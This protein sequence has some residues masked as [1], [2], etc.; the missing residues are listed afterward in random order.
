[1]PL[2]RQV[3]PSD[4]SSGDNDLSPK[5]ASG[6]I[7]V[8]PLEQGFQ[9]QREHEHICSYGD[10]AGKRYPGGSCAQGRRGN[11]PPG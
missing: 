2:K 6:F 7:V 8:L 3:V 10:M 5:W 11:D 1:M 9:K 4:G